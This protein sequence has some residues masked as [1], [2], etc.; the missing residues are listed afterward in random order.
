MKKKMTL[1]LIAIGLVLMMVL[2][3]C[4]GNDTAPAPSTDNTAPAAPSDDAPAQ[5]APG[6][7]YQ[8]RD[9]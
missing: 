5:D 4:G 8:R 1:K 2:A 9:N 3:G 6:G 7:G